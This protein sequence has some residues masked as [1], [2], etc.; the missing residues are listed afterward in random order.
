MVH[1]EHYVN[2]PRSF[3][4]S[5]HRLLRL[6]TRQIAVVISMYGL[7]VV[8]EGNYLPI[9]FGVGHDQRPVLVIPCGRDYAKALNDIIATRR[10]TLAK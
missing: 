9:F 8:G 1:V 3:F 7:Q 5:G 6:V 10:K 4:C 2:H